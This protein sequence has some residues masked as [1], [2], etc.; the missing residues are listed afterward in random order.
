MPTARTPAAVVV[1]CAIVLG[2]LAA[3]PSAETPGDR[4]VPFHVGETLTYDVSWSTF[5]T[6]G[7]VTTSVQARRPLE[8]GGSAYDIIAEGKPG[9]VLDAIY[10]LYYKAETLLDTRTLQP[11]VI[12]VFSAERGRTKVRTTR[13]ASATSIEFQPDAAAA[14]ERRAVPPLS[15]DPLSATYVMRAAPL[16]AGLI[17]TM[18]VVDG[19]DVYNVRWQIAGPEP[20]RTALGSMSAWRLTPALTTLDGKAVTNRQFSLWISDDARRWP[21]KLQAGLAVG[22]F[23]LTLARASG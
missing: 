21:L 3:T 8:A 14:W 2:W 6:A 5:L 15:Q 7:T 22:S 13:F 9:T 18:P 1:A 20:I 4:A 23:T 16:R 19:S 10:H 17:L 11:S 12:S